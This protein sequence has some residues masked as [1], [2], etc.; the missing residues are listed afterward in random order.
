MRHFAAA[1][2]LFFSA[3]RT[4]APAPPPPVEEVPPPVPTA[5]ERACLGAIEQA[6]ARLAS[7]EFR[8]CERDSDCQGVSPLLSGRCGTFANAKRFDEHLDEFRAQTQTCRPVVQIMPRCVRLQPVCRANRCEGEPIATIPD[9]CDELGKALAADADRAN[10]CQADEDCASLGEDERPTSTAF[11]AAS[12]ERQEKLARACGT[13]PPLLS[14]VRRMPSDA[15]CVAGRCS[16]ER[17]AA[18]FTTVVR[19]RLPITRPKFESDC[20]GEQFLA[21]FKQHHPRG[22]EWL[23]SFVANID[24]EGRANQF[25]F[26]VPDDLSVEAQH[27]LASRIAQCRAEP[28]RYRGKPIAV[29]HRTTIKWLRR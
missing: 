11:L 4:P 28:A 10:T 27:A 1:T 23:L 9:E 8:G 15:F 21:S 18:K 26:Q 17:A 13:I 5:E 22:R 7:D 12:L 14:S 29:R 20:L 6:G 24:E 19:D 2:F 3:C 16:N 25:E